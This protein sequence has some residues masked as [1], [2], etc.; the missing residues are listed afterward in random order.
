L[1]TQNELELF[2]DRIAK[3]ALFETANIVTKSEPFASK[4]E[5]VI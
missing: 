1:K 3:L 2:D 4:E 5:A